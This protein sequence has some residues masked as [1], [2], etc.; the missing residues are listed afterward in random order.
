MGIFYTYARYTTFEGLP[1]FLKHLFAQNKEKLIYS[2][3]TAILNRDPSEIEKMPIAELEQEFHALRRLVASKAGFGGFTQL[4]G[5]REKI[6]V[7]VVRALKLGHDGISHA[8]IDM[9]CTLME[10]MHENY[11]LK[12]EQLNKSSLLSSEKFLDG[13]LD[14]WTFHVV[15][16]TF[17]FLF[18][19]R[20][21]RRRCIILSLQARGTGALIVAAMLDFLTFALCAPYS[22]TTDGKQFD[23][24]LAKVADRGRTLYKLFQLPSH[25]IVKVRKILEQQ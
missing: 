22:E 18:N 12:Q 16:V 11:D 3:L 24:L 5:F 7:K 8:A 13:L 20:C 1:F 25:T 23:I 17:P 10:P 14:M 2:A 6:G 19:T 21:I 4:P 15:S 9:I